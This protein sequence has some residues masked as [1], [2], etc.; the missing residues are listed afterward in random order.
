[1]E[2]F[3]VIMPVYRD[4]E[5]AVDTVERFISADIPELREF[6]VVVDEEDIEL[7]W[8]RAIIVKN[9]RRVGKSRAV[10]QGLGVSTAPVKVLIS[11]DIVIEPS[12]VREMASRVEDGGLVVPRIVPEQDGSI[13]SRV[14]ETVWQ[15]HH[16]VSSISPTAGE[17]IAFSKELS[18]PEKTVADE[19]YISS[20]MGERTYLED[21]KVHNQPPSS[22]KQLYLQRRRIFMGHLAL[23]RNEGY[24]PPT[25]S[26]PLLLAGLK[27]YLCEGGEKGMLARASLIELFA[28]SEGFL[29]FLLGGMPWKWKTINTLQ[30]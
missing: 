23:Q 24:V 26:F 19:E 25:N 5:S 29:R 20:K 22:L 3:S 21:E 16:H 6:V 7:D 30:T 14:A 9:G 13:A 11:S 10:N 17:A 27:S 2:D 8:D 12:T 28:R 15:L 1:M 18:L 4:V